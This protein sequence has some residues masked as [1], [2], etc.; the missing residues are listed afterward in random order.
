MA[1]IVVVGSLNMD[2]V[3]SAPR[4]PVIGETII[5]DA[6]FAEPGGKGANQAYAAAR[7]GGAVAMLGLIGDDE[8]GRRM[9]D[10]LSAAGCDTSAV[11][12]EP[13]SSG[14]ALIFVSATGQNSIIVVP[15]ANARLQPQHLLQGGD[16]MSGST[17]A[18]LQLENPVQ[19]VLAA[20]QMARKS[21]ALVILDPAPAPAT[22]LP[23]E[24]LKCI[25]VL[26]P[27]ETEGAILTG[28]APGRLEA[29]QAAQIGMALRKKGAAAVVMK[30]GDQ[31]C[32]LITDGIPVHLPTPKVTAVDTTGAGDVFNGAL[33]VGL[34][35]G[36]GLQAAC[37]FANRAAALSVMRRGAQ[38][39]VPSRSEVDRFC[40]DAIGNLDGLR[41]A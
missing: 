1:K 34:S 27:N 19:T 28:V 10:N 22:E 33:A 5:G 2:L 31:G 25:D 40:F 11:R 17:V 18:L 24:L 4:I 26:T 32:L 41:S 7:L 30:L 13:G 15:G 6:Y 14:V 3:A 36:L 9:R 29:E 12:A 35:E 8:F 16:I 23:A 21:G 39:G 20:A 38:T 37:G